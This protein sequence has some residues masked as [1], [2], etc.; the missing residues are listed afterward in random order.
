MSGKA[1]SKTN[2]LEEMWDGVSG[3][4]EGHSSTVWGL[5]GSCEQRGRQAGKEKGG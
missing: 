4:T 1:V 3:D 5:V 2:A